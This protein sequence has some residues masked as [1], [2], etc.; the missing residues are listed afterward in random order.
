M[1]I[2]FNENKHNGG[3][4][5]CVVLRLLITITISMLYEISIMS[6]L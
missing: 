1:N 2:F 6:P 4:P 3:T 5:D